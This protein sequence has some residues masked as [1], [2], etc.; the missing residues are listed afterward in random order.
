ME[1]S[2]A[3]RDLRLDLTVT[4]FR[5]DDFGELRNLMQASIR[6]LLSMET[7][8]YL[9]DEEEIEEADE[10]I[11]ITVDGPTESPLKPAQ[12]RNQEGENIPDPDEICRKVVK[13]LSTPTRDL[14]SCM[15]EGLRRCDAALM[16]LSGYRQHL[17]PPKDVSPDVV[18]LQIRMR[19][20][21]AAFD[22][23][24][25][26]LL[27]SGD[28]PSSSIQ[29]SDI[30]QLFVFARHVREAAATIDDLMAKVYAMQHISDWPKMYLPSYPFWKALHRTNPQIRH[31]I[32]GITAGSYHVTFAEIARLLNKIKSREHKPSR[33]AS[34]ESEFITP[35]QSH[36]TMD[37][38]VDGD[39]TSK[40]SELGYKTWRVLRH[41]QGF[42]GRYAF[43]VCL[44]TSLLSVP[45]YLLGSKDWWDRYEAWWAVSLAWI[46]MHPRVGG[47]FQD[48][49]TR[50]FAAISGAVWSGAAHAAG[51]G[52]P[53]VL[54]VFAAIYM[55]P[56]LYRFTQSS[57][58]VR[59]SLTILFLIEDDCFEKHADQ[60]R[61]GPV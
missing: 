22:A 15:S 30:V 17:G 18:P 36:A 25:S 35:Q 61:S 58:P 47:N 55:I 31:D 52:N 26:R 39:T 40:K 19:K 33:G 10:Q 29:D 4:R 24:E 6:A 37:A 3:Y 38:E 42:E 44:A 57:H 5:P 1:L 46:M 51:G 48:L 43:K 21:K 60:T 14:L 54:A 50:A 9:F 32:G 7:E 16:D 49:V 41:L 45:S 23:V 13:E 8:T 27:D 12:G 34:E 53:Y 56:M 11:A 59:C 28:L 20:S 2:Q